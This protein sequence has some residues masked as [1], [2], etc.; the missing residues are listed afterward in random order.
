MHYVPGAVALGYVD[1]HDFELPLPGP[2]FAEHISI[3]VATATATATASAAASWL[4]PPPLHPTSLPRLP[5]RPRES[6]D[7][8]PTAHG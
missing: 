7:S 3:L 5:R 4:T 6:S 8:G 2:D 1:N